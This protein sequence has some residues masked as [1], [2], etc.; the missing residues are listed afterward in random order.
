MLLRRALEDPRGFDGMN[1]QLPPDALGMIARFANGDARTA[2]SVLEMAVLNGESA[3]GSVQVSMEMLEQC[4]SRKSLLYDKKGEEHYN[5]ISA[6]HKSM[7]NSD[8]D[9]A[10][11]WLA[12]MLEAG[13]DPL[14]VAR[15]VVR[16]AS[17][18]VGLADPRAL[19]LA[20]AAYQACHFIGMPECSVHLTQAVVYLSLAPKSNALYTAYEAA[21]TDALRQLAEPV[22]LVIR[23]AVTPL[24]AREGYGQG[25]QYAHDAQDKLTTMQCLPDSLKGKTYYHPTGQGLE[26]RFKTRLEEIRAWHKH[27]G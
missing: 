19:E 22:P 11:Y 9:A 20:V 27:N 26:T 12:R 14:Y 1:V 4:L 25:Y 13:E 24:M 8:P 7:R 16:F 10:V 3:E 18:D 21:K 6:L 2:L 17:E 5:L 15:R 23:N